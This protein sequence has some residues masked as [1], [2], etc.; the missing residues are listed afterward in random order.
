MIMMVAGDKD[1]SHMVPILER[2]MS[3]LSAE[4]NI[5]D[6]ILHLAGVSGELSQ[7]AL[8]RLPCTDSYREKCLYLLKKEDLIR[9]VS[10]DDIE[11]IRLTAKG[12]QYLVKAYP[13]RFADFYSCKVGVDKVRLDKESRLRAMRISESLLF[14]YL[15]GV[16][17]FRD[18]RPSWELPP[19]D[20]K[21][22]SFYSSYEIKAIGEEGKKMLN[23]RFSGL[24]RS[25]SG[26]YLLYSIGDRLIKWYAVSES[27]ARQI[28]R[29]HINSDVES[30]ILA[31]DMTT[32]LSILE[33][34]QKDNNSY[35][36]LN[37]YMNAM[38]FYPNT[39]E[40]GLLFRMNVMTDGMKRL[41]GMLL[42]KFHLLPSPNSLECDG[43]I[44][45]TTAFL[46]ACPF[47]LVRIQRFK[48]GCEGRKLTPMVLCFDCQSDVLQSYFDDSALLRTIALK[49]AAELLQIGDEPS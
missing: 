9:H 5:K 13:E 22:A 45:D 31:R 34:E 15:Q 48:I 33:A 3:E 43:F 2:R 4:I 23:A 38:Y 11:G 29:S 28:I 17:A 14:L 42:P 39:D 41:S 25:F 20:V 37:S 26:N 44:D 27:R 19:A 47:D 18:D 32:A 24:L 46:F 49:Q 16:S 10:R 12:K 40:G 6:L 7:T 36:Y 21:K 1:S 30:I 8:E 35:V